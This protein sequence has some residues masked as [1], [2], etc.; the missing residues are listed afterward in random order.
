MK[1][2]IATVTTFGASLYF[3]LPAMAAATPINLCANVGGLDL[4]KITLP[5][6]LLSGIQ[7]ILVV[8]VILAFVFLVIGGIKWILSGGDKGGTE[9]AKGTITAA[10][11]GLVIVF[12][13][14][15]LL[16]VIGNFFGVDTK[17]GLSLPTVSSID[18]NG[19]GLPD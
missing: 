5:T 14:W 3:A 13:A 9:A 4:C 18:T 16:N 10:L 17:G 12:V 15:M 11:I 19:D 6:V 1:K 8:A 7:F 2:L